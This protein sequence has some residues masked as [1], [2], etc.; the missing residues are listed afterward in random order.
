[1]FYK[2]WWLNQHEKYKGHH[3]K[4][5]HEINRPMAGA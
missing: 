5:L 3:N 4:N 2:S 1:M